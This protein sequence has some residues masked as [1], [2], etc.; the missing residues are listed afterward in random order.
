MN[1][2]SEVNERKKPSN[3]AM[4]LKK[5]LIQ[6][7]STNYVNSEKNPNGATLEDV[8]LS[9][10]AKH[11]KTFSSASNQGEKKN[12][13]SARESSLSSLRKGHTISKGKASNEDS[14][15]NK[16]EGYKIEY[17][18][19][20]EDSVSVKSNKPYGTSCTNEE[21]SYWSNLCQD[22]KNNNEYKYELNQLE[23]DKDNYV[24]NNSIV[25]FSCFETNL[26]K[27]QKH[28]QQEINYAPETENRDHL[29]E[30]DENGNNIQ[31]DTS[32]EASLDF[33]VNNENNDNAIPSVHLGN[34]QEVN[35][36][37]HYQISTEKQAN[38]SD[39]LQELEDDYEY[40]PK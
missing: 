33:S 23:I 39:N 20:G 27:Y 26:S 15:S 28:G 12:R 16:V 30:A 36:Q 13:N 3:A 9:K 5:K 35:Q 29:L 11:K 22:R 25:E 14:R 8:Y 21:I 7:T 1:R 6:I 32:M 2:Q 4:D 40:D 31:F 17:Q 37:E 10:G 19:Y 24:N 18:S 38:S 34:C